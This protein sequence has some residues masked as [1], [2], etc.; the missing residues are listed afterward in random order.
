MID[1]KRHAAHVP[2]SGG[3]FKVGVA[4]YVD[5]SVIVAAL[6]NETET[7]RMQSRCPVSGFDPADPQFDRKGGGKFRAT[8]SLMA[9]SA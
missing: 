3:W 4:R 9:S 7:G 5:T 2:E 8:Q 6:T 1:G